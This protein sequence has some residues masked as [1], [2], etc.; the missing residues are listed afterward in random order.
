[1]VQSILDMPVSDLELMLNKQ[2]KRIIELAKK[3]DKLRAELDTVESELENLGVASAPKRSKLVRRPRV[4]NK[5][6]LHK[7]VYEVLEQNPKGL[8][9]NE[10]KDKVLETGYQTKSAD[11]GNVLYQCLY[12]RPKMFRKDDKTGAYKV[13]GKTT[14]KK[15]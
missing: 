15:S 8:T 11:F 10:L 6:P 13:V 1:M 4:K 3:R 5:M 2:K 14:R 7:T 9:I 12:N